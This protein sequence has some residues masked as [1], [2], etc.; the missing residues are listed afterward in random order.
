VTDLVKFVSHYAVFH[1]CVKSGLGCS[2][3]ACSRNLNL[4]VPF[5]ICGGLSKVLVFRIVN[6]CIS[7]TYYSRVLASLESIM[8]K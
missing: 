4:S 3:I 8:S 5:L 6:S 2:L 1:D 7:P